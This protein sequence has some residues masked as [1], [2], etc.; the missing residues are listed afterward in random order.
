MD[1]TWDW[2]VGLWRSDGLDGEVRISQSFAWD[3]VSD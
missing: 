2:E 3:V 1:L